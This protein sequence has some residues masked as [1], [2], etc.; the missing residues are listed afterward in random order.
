MTCQVAWPWPSLAFLFLTILSSFFLP[1]RFWPGPVL[2]STASCT[3]VRPGLLCHLHKIPALM[4]R[5]KMRLSLCPIEV[6]C[7]SKREPRGGGV[8]AGA[9]VHCLTP[10]GQSG[11]LWD[12]EREAI[13]GLLSEVRQTEECPESGA[14]S[15]GKDHRS[16]EW[17]VSLEP[18]WIR[19]G[20]EIACMGF[21]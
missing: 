5:Q 7:I 21:G 3:P 20:R 2:R 15:R 6:S 13:A 8:P 14:N 19:R 12:L 10:E 16:S 18:L 11:S 9:G 17:T 4:P 1:V